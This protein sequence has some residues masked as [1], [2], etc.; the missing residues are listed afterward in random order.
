MTKMSKKPNIESQ[1]KYA[2]FNRRII[3]FGIDVVLITLVVTPIMNLLLWIF[4]GTNSA[5]FVEASR[6]LSKITLVENPSVLTYVWSVISNA[7][8]MIIQSILLLLVVVYF[9]YFWKKLGASIGKLI[10]GCRIVDAD[11]YRP[12][13]MKQA[14]KRMFGHVLNVLTVG[15]GLFMADFT[16]RKQGLHDKIANTVVIIKK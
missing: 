13:T 10:M 7:R 9:I 12:I 8:Y 1:Y 2:S 11:N 6:N 3:A 5:Y 16:K 14:I 15:I 4:F